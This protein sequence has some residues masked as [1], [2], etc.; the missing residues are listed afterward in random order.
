M[1]NS[2][3]ISIVKPR[4]L[5][6]REV[7]RYSLA[8][9][10]S[11][12]GA[13]LFPSEAMANVA[14]GCLIRHEEFVRVR[15][16]NTTFGNSHVSLFDR[17]KHI[18]TTGDLALDRALDAAIKRL[19]DLFRQVPAFGFYREEDHPDISAM[20]AFAT[21]EGTDIPGTWGTVGFGVTLFQREMSQFDKSGS[22][23]VAIIAH[24]FGHIWAM[25]AGVFG[26]FIKGQKTVKRSELHADFL[27]GYFLGIRKRAAP[28]ISLQSAGDLFNRIGD[29]R[30][31]RYDHHGTPVERVA[32]A[33]E[34]F[35]V[36]Y[37]QGRDADYAFAAGR[38]YVSRL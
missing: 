11:A 34:G 31:D 30:I 25:K 13:T 4:G 10:A 37:L 29:N 6:R 8:A 35:K 18:R 20:N 27:A 38:E 15:S 33:E 28:D 3:D 36:S 21:Q 1:A 2:R 14:G 26:E 17:G 7:G 5:S 19:S 9:V 23:I 16:A 24:E 12:A 22:T 32:A